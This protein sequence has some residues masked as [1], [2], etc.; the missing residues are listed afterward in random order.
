MIKDFDALK[1]QLAELAFEGDGVAYYVPEK[2]DH[3]G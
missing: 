2:G 1:K 3:H